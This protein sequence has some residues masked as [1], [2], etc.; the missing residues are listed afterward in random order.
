M[1]GVMAIEGVVT[2]GLGAI[3]G[4]GLGWLMAAAIALQLE[5]SGYQLKFGQAGSA[6]ISAVLIA[7]ALGL[8]AGSIP[9]SP[10]PARRRRQGPRSHDVTAP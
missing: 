8:L 5:Q 9:R 1:L 7:M 10:C 6:E 2:A 3:A 4:I